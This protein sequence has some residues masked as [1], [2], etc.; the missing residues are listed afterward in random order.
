MVAVRWN[1]PLPGERDVE[2]LPI[3]L[4]LQRNGIP[5][6]QLRQSFAQMLQ[7]TDFIADARRRNMQVESLAPDR[8]ARLV[9]EAM[10]TPGDVMEDTRQMLR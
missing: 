9:A 3:A 10:A 4:D 6:L 1:Q 2:D 5:P 8:L 7:D